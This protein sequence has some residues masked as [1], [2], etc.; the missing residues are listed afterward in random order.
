M[1][2]QK[3]PAPTLDQKVDE[4]IRESFPASDSPA[5][6]SDDDPPGNAQALWR[7]AA[8]PDDGASPTDKPGTGFPSN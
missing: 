7:R 4:S 3:P 2:A 1:E 5:V 8:R 6:S